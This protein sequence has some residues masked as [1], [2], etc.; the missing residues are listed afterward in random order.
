MSDR[1]MCEHKY[2]HSSL[3]LHHKWGKAW[4][5][6]DQCHSQDLYGVDIT[7]I[8]FIIIIII[9]LRVWK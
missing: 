6:D 1:E 4:N 7:A 9:I 2:T 8:I 3:N 5:I